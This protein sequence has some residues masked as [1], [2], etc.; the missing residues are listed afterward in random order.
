ML[1]SD[2]FRFDMFCSALICSVLICYVL[3]C[4]DMICSNMFCS[5]LFCS[6]MIYALDF[7]KPLDYYYKK[8]DIGYVMNSVKDGGLVL[9]SGCLMSGLVCDGCLN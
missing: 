9:P 5:D 8:D 6:V 7:D 3:S 1:C 2:L 4:S